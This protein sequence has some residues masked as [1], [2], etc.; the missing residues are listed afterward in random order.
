MYAWVPKFIEQA[1]GFAQTDFFR[2]HLR[3]VHGF[4]ADELDQLEELLQELSAVIFFPN[5]IILRNIV[6]IVNLPP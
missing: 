6:S 4:L 1:A 3:M 5:S 2:G